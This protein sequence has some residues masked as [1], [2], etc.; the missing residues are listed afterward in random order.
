VTGEAGTLDA[1]AGWVN[2]VGRVVEAVPSAKIV[3]LQ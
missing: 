2:L 1:C 3:R